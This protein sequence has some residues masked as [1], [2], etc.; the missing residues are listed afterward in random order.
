MS[1]QYGWLGQEPGPKMI[2]E[3]LKLLGIRETMGAGNTPAIMT[4][5]HELGGDV[6]HVFTADAIPWCG[7]YMAIVAR[8]AGKTL[9]ASPLWARAWAI[10]GKKSPSPAL[11]DVL[12]FVR[13]GGGHVGLYVGEDSECFH[14]LGG[15]QADAVSIKRIDQH[16]CIAV[17]RSYHVTPDNVRPI[18]LSSA[19]AV[20]RDE[21]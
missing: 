3:G 20:S 9:P 17:R 21:A 12:V 2:V 15:N 16:R 11:G 8:R 18:H 1:T 19:G 7:L 13:D 5:A 10:W 6:A 4:W 14:V